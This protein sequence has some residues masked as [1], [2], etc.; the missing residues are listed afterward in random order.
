VRVVADGDSRRIELPSGRAIHYHDVAWERYRV[1]DP[2]TGKMKWKEGWRYA[3]PKNPF[4]KNMR[5]GTYGGRLAENVTQAVARD[6]LAEALIRLQSR[7]YAVVG[8]VHDEVLV[9]G[10]D[11]EEV[12]RVISEPPAWAA[13]LPIGAEGF[14]CRRYRKG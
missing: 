5:I 7:G 3:N 8:H 10:T 13:G 11:Y 9:E 12:S 1:K 6:V 2:K 4:N 14:T